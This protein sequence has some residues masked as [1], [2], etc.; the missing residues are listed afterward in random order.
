MVFFIIN[1]LIAHASPHVGF[2]KSEILL[3]ELNERNGGK[4]IMQR[5]L[6][7]RHPA[8]FSNF[9]KMAFVVRPVSGLARLDS[10]PSQT[11]VLNKLTKNYLNKTHMVQWRFDESTLAYRCGGSIGI[12]N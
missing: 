2:I 6:N 3:R 10:S 1:S 4:Q 12:A 7:H 5:V 8:V 9:A 11:N